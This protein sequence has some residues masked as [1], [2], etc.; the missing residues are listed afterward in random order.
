MGEWRG[1]GNLK[2]PLNPTTVIS[3]LPA[4]PSGDLA[5]SRRCTD[6][7]KLTLFSSSQVEQVS[8]SYTV[9][10]LILTIFK[11]GGVQFFSAEV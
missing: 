3:I 9:I 5:I 4:S 7:A 8:C 6:G 10:D 1:M 11:F 2:W